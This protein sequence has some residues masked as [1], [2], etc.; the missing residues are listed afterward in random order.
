MYNNDDKNKIFFTIIIA[1]IRPNNPMAL[2][3]IS[4]IRILTK[5]AGFAA[6]ARAAPDPTMPTAKPQAKL[7]KPTVSPAANMIY[8][9]K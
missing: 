2:A 1:T 7:H 9:K 8:P 4:T 3:K 6:S 5:S